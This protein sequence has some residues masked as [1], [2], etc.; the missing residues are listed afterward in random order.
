MNC[1]P[2]HSF[3]QLERKTYLFF[4]SF[5][6]RSVE[7]WVVSQERL[8]TKTEVASSLEPP[9]TGGWQDGLVDIGWYN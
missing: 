6:R 5:H 7:L 3:F 1:H 8:L 4:A 9:G 2:F